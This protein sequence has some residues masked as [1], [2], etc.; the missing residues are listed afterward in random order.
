MHP[1]IREAA[2]TAGYTESDGSLLILSC[3]AEELP[4]Y[5]RNEGLSVDV[6]ICI[7]VICSIPDAER[8]ITKLTREALRP[9]GLLLFYEHVRS[10]RPDV[11][12]WQRFWTPFWRLCFDGCKLDVPAHVFIRDMIDSDDHGSM[13]SMWK[14]G[15][16]FGKPD[17]PEENL[18]WHQAGRFVKN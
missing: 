15:E 5:L 13:R 3:P 2:N 4:T 18:F 7:L 12:W 11:A 16:T 1:Y 9:G 17:E 10:H 8:V 14:E 6:I